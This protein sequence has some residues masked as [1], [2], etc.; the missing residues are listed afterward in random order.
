MSRGDG[1]TGGKW[2]GRAHAYAETFAGQCAHT[3]PVL[4]DALDP[5]PGSRLLDVG[6]GA[7]AVA[8]AAVARGCAVT[9]VDP[10]ADMLELAAVAA[11]T[12]SLVRASLPGLPFP[13]GAFDLVSANF[14]V[15]HVPDPRAAVSELARV[16][17][18]G[19]RLGV[20]VWPDDPT[21]LRRLWDDVVRE[22]G[23]RRPESAAPLPS[24]LDF[25][26]TT[27]GLAGLLGSAGLRVERA[28]R[29]EFSHVVEPDLWWSGVTRGVANIGQTY[30]A[31]DEFGRSAMTAAF[32]RLSAPY[33]RADGRL[34]LAGAAVLALAVR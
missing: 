8:A 12:A 10:A 26:R 23:V 4:L 28:W 13:D 33:L 20:S 34:Q 1:Q 29:H 3:I 11:P 24:D 2:A 19:G 18:P 9:A 27:E 30:L 7:G 31:Q 15:N 25:P 21:P 6:T 17:A 14:V 22:A 16:L 5:R 32:D